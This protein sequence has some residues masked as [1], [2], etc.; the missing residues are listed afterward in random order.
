MPSFCINSFTVNKSPRE[1]Q[2]REMKKRESKL[3]LIP[4]TSKA[5]SI[6]GKPHTILSMAPET[7]E[8]ATLP[9]WELAR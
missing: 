5:R 4:D 8:A 3:P 1:K 7:S 2:K 6:L 9:S